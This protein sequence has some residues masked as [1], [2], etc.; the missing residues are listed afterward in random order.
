MET[1]YTS[2]DKKL[3]NPLFVQSKTENLIS[4]IGTEEAKVLEIVSKAEEIAKQ[5]CTYSNSKY[6]LR[7]RKI[8][9]ILTS[10]KFGIPIMIVFLALI[11]WI[12]ITRCKL[13]ILSLI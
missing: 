12:T 1:I 7:T 8:D 10:K 13:S 11:L 6:E 5:V 2:I 4:T 9:N 3:V